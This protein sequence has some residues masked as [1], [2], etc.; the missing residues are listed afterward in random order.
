MWLRMHPLDFLSATW[1]ISA[2]QTRAGA[3]YSAR[4]A[5]TFWMAWLMK[6]VLV[7]E[8]ELL[9]VMYEGRSAALAV[10]ARNA[11]KAVLRTFMVAC[12]QG[13]EAEGD[14]GGG[15]SSR[16]VAASRDGCCFIDI[17]GED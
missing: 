14:V 17:R 1:A 8:G 15:P 7:G 6:A 10:P 3:L 13:T 11:V 12:L 16:G 5:L 2:L 9:A 4:I